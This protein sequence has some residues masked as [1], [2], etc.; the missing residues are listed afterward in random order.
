MPL[1]DEI[2]CCYNEQLRR[3]LGD[4]QGPWLP[5]KILCETR[6][7][8]VRLGESVEQAEFAANEERRIAISVYR[9]DIYSRITR[10]KGTRTT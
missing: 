4:D 9:K 10:T 7:K 2:E 8:Q 1:R 5:P 6:S 3:H